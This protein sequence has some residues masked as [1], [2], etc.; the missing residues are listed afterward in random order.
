MFRFKQNTFTAAISSN[1]FVSTNLL[2]SKCSQTLC[3]GRIETQ[4]TRHFWWK[5]Q[6]MDLAAMSVHKFD[7]DLIIVIIALQLNLLLGKHLYANNENYTRIKL[8][9]KVLPLFMVLSLANFI[10]VVVFKE[11]NLTSSQS[12][13]F[14]ASLL[15]IFF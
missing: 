4:K 6:K 10:Y 9:Y 11:T 2:C 7:Y 3:N 8:I 14:M 5:R 15:G 13:Y 1:S 12:L